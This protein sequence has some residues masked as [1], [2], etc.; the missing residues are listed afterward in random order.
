MRAQRPRHIRDAAEI[1]CRPGWGSMGGCGPPDV[2][3]MIGVVARRGIEGAVGP[4]RA[5]LLLEVRIAA[6][7]S[8]GAS[9]SS[10]TC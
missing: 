4:L 3:I 2:M 9:R 5:R 8:G 6:K 10:G 1:E 7:L